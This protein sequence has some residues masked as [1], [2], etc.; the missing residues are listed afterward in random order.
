MARPSE[1]CVRGGSRSRK[2]LRLERGSLSV[3]QSGGNRLPHHRPDK[4]LVFPKGELPTP[5][6]VLDIILLMLDSHLRALFPHLAIPRPLIESAN[7]V[8]SCDTMTILS[9]PLGSLTY[10]PYL[11]EDQVLSPK[12]KEF[13]YCLSSYSGIHKPVLYEIECSISMLFTKGSLASWAFQ[14]ACITVE[15]K[16]AESKRALLSSEKS[17]ALLRQSYEIFV[18]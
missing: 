5:Q 9:F 16:Q 13:A 17:L 10:A 14:Q 6:S 7:V 2:R 1:S 3:V 15:A 12:L 8:D 4:Q 18:R 11:G